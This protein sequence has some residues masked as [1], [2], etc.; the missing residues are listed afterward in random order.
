MSAILM[1][2]VFGWPAILLSLG[3]A[4]AG[5]LFKKWNLTLVGA[6][7]FLLPGWSVGQYFSLSLLLPLLMFGSAYAIYKGKIYLAFLL[8]LPILIV[9]ARLGYL[10]LTQRPLII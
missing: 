3:L 4:L 6:I 5:I 10:V 2:I 9:I 8:I 1:Q 7:L